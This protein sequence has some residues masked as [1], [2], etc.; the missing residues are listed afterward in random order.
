MRTQL[1]GLVGFLI[2]LAVTALYLQARRKHAEPTKVEQVVARLWLLLRRAVA[3]ILG[4][5]LLGFAAAARSER[6]WLAV[7]I[8][9]LA[10]ALFYFA[11]VG[12]GPRRFDWR[13]DIALHKQNRKRFGWWL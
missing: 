2:A 7:G 8:A 5:G 4:V 13:D 11:A 10:L 9:V 12:Q 6:P 3:I 1:L